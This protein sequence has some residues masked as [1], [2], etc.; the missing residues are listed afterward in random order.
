VLPALIPIRASGTWLA[1]RDVQRKRPTETWV[2]CKLKVGSHVTLRIARD[3]QFRNLGVTTNSPPGVSECKV[4]EGPHGRL[5]ETRAVRAADDSP[6][7]LVL[8]VVTRLD[9]LRRRTD[10]SELPLELLHPIGG[11]LRTA[12]AHEQQ[13]EYWRRSSASADQPAPSVAERNRPPSKSGHLCE[14]GYTARYSR[15]RQ[16]PVNLSADSISA[17]AAVPTTFQRRSHGHTVPIQQGRQ[18]RDPVVRGHRPSG[19]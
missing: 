16:V 11:D 12:A 17:G 5:V 8:R 14:R 2:S 4:V 7:G 18:L 9:R 6:V 19:R 10:A 15:S 3:H 13:Q 1:D